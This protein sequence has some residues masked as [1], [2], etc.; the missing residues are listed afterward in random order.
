[1]DFVKEKGFKP[2]INSKYLKTARFNYNIRL[3][4]V[5]KSNQQKYTDK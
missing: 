3:N 5:L 2:Q 4:P 1:M